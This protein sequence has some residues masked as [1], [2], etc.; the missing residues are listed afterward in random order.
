[1]SEPWW[2]SGVSRSALGNSCSSLGETGNDQPRA[3]FCA[4]WVLGAG[5]GRLLCCF[6]AKW[7]LLLCTGCW[8][9]QRC[10]AFPVSSLTWAGLALEGVV[11]GCLW[12]E[13]WERDGEGTVVEIVFVSVLNILTSLSCI[14]SKQ[15]L[16]GLSPSAC[17]P[18]SALLIKSC[19]LVPWAA[20]CCTKGINYSL[21]FKE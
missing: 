4:E 6:P 21:Y 13:G 2:D 10:C 16:W 15:A 12:D 14:S 11:W 20:L 17:N 18:V 1:M 3:A 8:Q 9:R 7:V 5:R 19:H